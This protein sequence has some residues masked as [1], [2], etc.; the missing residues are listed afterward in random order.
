MLRRRAVSES[1]APQ[2]GVIVSPPGAGDLFLD[3]RARRSYRSPRVFSQESD[4]Q[5]I[6]HRGVVVSRLK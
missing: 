2:T 3:G 5:H 1:E 4:S 6:R